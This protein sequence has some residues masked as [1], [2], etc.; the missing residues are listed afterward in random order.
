MAE[1]EK[2]TKRPEEVLAD[3][4]LK[5]GGKKPSG[6]GGSSSQLVSF[7]VSAVL[8]VVIAVAVA[9]LLCYPKS[10][11]EAL[12]TQ[13]DTAS[14]AL[15][16]LNSSLANYASTAD[17]DVLSDE[18]SALQVSVGGPG[19]GLTGS[20]EDL[21]SQLAS[22]SGIV[23][24]LPNTT[25]AVDALAG[26]LTS[27]DTRLSLLAAPRLT[28]ITGTC[29]VTVNSSGLGLNESLANGL[30]RT[31]YAGT[32]T[33]VTLS[34]TTQEFSGWL[35]NGVAN[36]SHS[37]TLMVDTDILV[38]AFT[39]RVIPTITV[40]LSTLRMSNSSWMVVGSAVDSANRSMTFTWT[41]TAGDFLYFQGNTSVLWT[42]PA[43][44]NYSATCLVTDDLGGNGSASTS[45]T[46]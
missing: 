21:N 5:G 12:K 4:G 22:L 9:M 28:V 46:W 30:Q 35:I 31:Y 18:I 37:I 38:Q 16:A 1:G 36:T 24:G 44:G 26:S 43:P 10:D 15:L 45:V 41:K 13:L 34:T 14:N 7:L 2:V 27:F 33:T 40:S 39:Q 6:R 32:P 3:L 23:T 42:L 8:A 17:V 11:G 29:N 20:V 25:A 19:A